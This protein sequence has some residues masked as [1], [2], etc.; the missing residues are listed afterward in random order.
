MNIPQLGEFKNKIKWYIYIYVFS[1]DVQYIDI[2]VKMIAI[3][4]HILLLLLF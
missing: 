2:I 1:M 3:I 4:Y